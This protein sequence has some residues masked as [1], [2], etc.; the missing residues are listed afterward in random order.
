MFF[1]LPL[2]TTNT[3]TESTSTPLYWP[4]FQSALTSPASTSR[5]TSGSSAKC[6]KSAS[7]PASTARLWSPEEPYDWLK[8]TSL[9]SA[10]F[11]KAGISSA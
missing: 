6:R 7:W 3:T 10:V 8:S 9:P 2:R 1:G 11:W 5:V 4:V